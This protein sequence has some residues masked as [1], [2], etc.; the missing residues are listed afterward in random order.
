MAKFKRKTAEERKQEIEDLTDGFSEKIDS[1]FL[2]EDKLKEHLDFMSK[3]HNYS[4]R[5]MTLIDKQ[6]QGARAVGSYNYWKQKGVHVKKGEKGIKILAP[7]PV[8]YFSRNNEK[9]QV[10]YATKEEKAKIKSGQIS[11]EKKM[12]F[13]VGHV[14]EYTQTNAREKDLEVS[15]IFKSYHRDGTIENDKAFINSLEKVAAKLGV[16]ILDEPK[17]EL[18]TAKG[19][20]YPYLKEIALNP[21]NSDYENVT[22]LIHELAHAKLHTPETR[23]NYTTEEKEFQAEMVSYVVANKYGIDTEEFSLS[24]L[25]NWTQGKELNDKE[26]LLKEV[27][28]TSKEFIDIIDQNLLEIEQVKENTINF[29]DDI[30]PQ[31]EI[32]SIKNKHNINDLSPLEVETALEINSKEDLSQYLSHK[33]IEE[34]K[35][36]LAENRV[37]EPLMLIHKENENDLYLKPFGEVNNESFED[38]DGSVKYTT[39]I[40]NNDELQVVSSSYESSEYAHPLHH[41]EKNN[42]VSEENYT[43]LENNFHEHLI[44]EDTKHLNNIA[45]SIRQALN[46][47]EKKAEKQD[48]FSM[49]R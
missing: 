16:E 14:F 15:D 23:D 48:E 30:K 47:E 3:F 5:N 34:N 36:Y 46:K 6:F 27:K 40:P 29:N 8:E 28:E 2:S 13:K 39:V 31:T 42:I 19:A 33:T 9:I 32:D 41:M 44:S 1:Y 11:T 25:G 35:T 21:R 20:S 10:R 12:F 18:G 24:Y 45:P 43:L 7:T 4:I 38:I 49:T 37:N 22:V 17:Q 26:N